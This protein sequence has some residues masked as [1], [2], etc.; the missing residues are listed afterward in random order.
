M[1]DYGDACPVSKATS[2]LC[3]RWTLQIVR[4]MLL[5]A[6]RFSEFQ[7]F[8]P[9]ISPSLLNARLR[10][11]EDNGIIVR[12]RIPEKRGFECRLTPAGKSLAP[13]LTE[14]GIWGKSWF[15][16]HAANEVQDIEGLLRAIAKLID[17]DRLPAGNHVF[18]FTFTDVASQPHWFI[19]IK[20]GTAEVCD[21]NM[22]YDVDLYFRSTYATLKR[23][24]WGEMSIASAMRDEELRVTGPVA[25]TR[26]LSRWFPV[27]GF[28]GCDPGRAG[29]ATENSAH[30]ATV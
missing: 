5:G 20:D 10:F 29:R 15:A 9:K 21:V 28:S 16:E 18:Q 14:L 6:S 27:N 7:K 23:I 26:S 19:T 12:R 2:L 17:L 24:W 13:L 25:Y 1:Y 22:G 3:E 8:L 11:L 30:G 4:E